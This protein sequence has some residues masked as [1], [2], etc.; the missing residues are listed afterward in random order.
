MPESYQRILVRATNWIGDAVMSLPALRALRARFPAARI[1]LLAMPWVADL[2]GREPFCDELIPWRAQ[3]GARD[4]AEKWRVG[5]SL[6]EHR[7]DLAIVLPNSF[8]SAL[9]AWLAGIPRRVGFD[10]DARGWLLTDRIAR[11][12]PGDTPPHQSFYY[13]ELLRRAGLIDALP[14]EVV[15]RLEGAA[16]ARERGRERLGSGRVVGVCP[17]AA[18]GGAKRWA[19]ERFAAAAAEIAERMGAGVLLFGSRDEVAICD[20]VNR[21]LG[22]AARSFAGATTLGEFVELLAACD[23]VLTNDSGPMHVASALGVPTVAVFGS[24][25]PIATGP[26]GPLARVVREAVACS[27]CFER[28]CPLSGVEANLA[29]LRGVRAQQVAAAALDLLNLRT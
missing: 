23:V 27:P 22:G 15:I 21:H 4:L 3:R 13:L 8:D 19:P 7:F 25:D 24:T 26:T 12:Q 16:V 9:P 10:R 5:R 6:A 18:F 2:Y 20:E 29:C 28:E 11:I 17:G 14:T 1:T